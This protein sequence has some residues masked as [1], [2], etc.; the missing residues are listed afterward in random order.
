MLVVSLVII[1]SVFA[2]IL[3]KVAN[4]TEI[5]NDYVFN[6]LRRSVLFLII[7]MM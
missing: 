1:N 7:D 2:Q 6:T 5:A 4:A 3:H